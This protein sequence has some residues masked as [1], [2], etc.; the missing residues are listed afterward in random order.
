M[1][2]GSIKWIT[3][4]KLVILMLEFFAGFL[5]GGFIAMFWMCLIKV[6]DK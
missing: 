4:I 1:F 2:L 5:V 6:E 3:T